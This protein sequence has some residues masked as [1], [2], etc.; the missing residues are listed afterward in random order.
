[1]EEVVQEVR[2]DSKQ[3]KRESR[4][5]TRPSSVAMKFRRQESRQESSACRP[6]ACL[7]SILCNLLTGPFRNLGTK[8]KAPKKEP[9]QRWGSSELAVQSSSVKMQI[10]GGII[11]ELTGALGRTWFHEVKMQNTNR[12]RSLV[13]F[14]NRST[15]LRASYYGSCCEKY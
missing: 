15:N 6:A 5:E 3:M 4:S 7:F 12:V 14:G 1:M 9:S 13:G 2:G 11:L 8:E 10:T